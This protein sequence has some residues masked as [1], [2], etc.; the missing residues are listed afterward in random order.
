[1]RRQIEVDFYGNN[2]YT[3]RFAKHRTAPAPDTD[4]ASNLDEPQENKAGVSIGAESG[5]FWLRS[6]PQGFRKHHVRIYQEVRKAHLCYQKRVPLPGRGEDEMS[7]EESV[8]DDYRQRYFSDHLDAMI[9]ATQD[10]AEVAGHFA[11]SLMD[12]LGE[13]FWPSRTF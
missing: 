1:L 5:T 3:F 2:Y 13:F 9:W 12:N 6:A 11:W 4:Y 8:N 7:K 10:G